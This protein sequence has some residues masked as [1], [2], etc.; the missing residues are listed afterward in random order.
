MMQ[1][2]LYPTL[3]LNLDYYTET[4]HYLGDISTAWPTLDPHFRLD[5]SVN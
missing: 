5:S 1:T 2:F 3:P 4:K